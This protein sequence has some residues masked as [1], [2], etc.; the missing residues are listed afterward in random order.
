MVVSD[1]HEQRLCQA[2]YSLLLK[3]SMEQSV[4]Y[5]GVSDQQVR[6]CMNVHSLLEIYNIMNKTSCCD[7][8]VIGTFPRKENNFHSNDL[9]MKLL[10][11]SE[12]VT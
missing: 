3:C 9:P 5:L 6:L 10:L 12:V 8:A 1:E 4:Y 7:V 2:K 11:L